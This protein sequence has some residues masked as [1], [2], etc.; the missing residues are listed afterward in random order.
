MSLDRPPTLLDRYIGA[1]GPARIVALSGFADMVGAGLHLAL[2]PIFL[3]SFVGLSATQIGFV[4]GL[5]GVVALGAPY[6]TGHIADRTSPLPVWRYSV[7]IRMVGYGAFALVNSLGAYVALVVVLTPLDR[8]SGTAQ[9]SYLVGSF[10]P[11]DRSRV[12]AAVRTCRNAGLS[13]GLLAASVFTVIGTKAAFQTAFVLNAA[14]FAVLLVGLS[15]LPPTRRVTKVVGKTKATPDPRS[16]V[17]PWTDRRYLG[18]TVGDGLMSV[19]VTVLFVVFPLW[20]AADDHFPIGLVGVFLAVNSVATV[21]LQ[22]IFADLG[23]GLTRASRLIAWSAASLMACG[24]FFGLASA[25]SGT[26]VVVLL[27][28]LAMLA[29]T[30]GENMHEVAVFEG[31]HRLAPEDAV[32]RYLGVFSLGDSTQRIVGPPLLTTLLVTNPIGWGVFVVMTGLGALSMR[33]A[34]RGWQ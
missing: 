30:L 34:M 1:R 20:A 26:A 15:R 3:V 24:V 7:A 18:L 23:T 31:S 5:A 19:H 16:S 17:S 25:A 4:V 8:A 33:R 9:M 13:V 22:P 2:L 32:G 12:T 28:L 11:D 21:V 6:L 29:L 10:P 27:A 14:T